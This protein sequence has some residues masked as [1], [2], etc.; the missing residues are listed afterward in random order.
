M[1]STKEHAR[2]EEQSECL[3]DLMG[4]THHATLPPSPRLLLDLGCGTGVV[5]TQL[6]NLYPNAQ[7]YGIDLSP[8]PQIH[9]PPTNVTYIQGD[10]HALP[11][12][13]PRLTPGQ[14]DLAFGR[15][16]V[17]GIRDW[18]ACVAAM[19]DQVRPGGWVELQDLNNRLFDASGRRVDTEMEWMRVLRASLE[20]KGLD[21]DA[22]INAEG[23][24]D[25]AG[26]VDIQSWEYKWTVGTW[27]ADKEPRTRRFGEFEGREMKEPLAVLLE[28]LPDRSAYTHEH[29]NSLK[30]QMLKDM[31]ARAE[32]K[33]GIYFTFTVTIGRRPLEN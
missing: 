21:P 5:T 24:L 19:R 27:L 4:C 23:Y 22:G 25:Q 11:R 2:L 29:I 7:V 31:E 12:L 20:A 9:R 1:H 15:L 13:D 17:C 28:E 26:L 16:L 6:G 3:A 18:P 32:G 10:L 33:S 8:V 30:K 14:A